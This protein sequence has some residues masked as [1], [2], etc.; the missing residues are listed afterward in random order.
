[1]GKRLDTPQGRLI[2]SYL[3][4]INLILSHIINDIDSLDIE[5][6]KKFYTDIIVSSLSEYEI[7]IIM[8]FMISHQTNRLTYNIRKLNFFDN[9]VIQDSNYLSIYIEHSI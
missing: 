6:G 5:E 8:G 7:V 9:V 4:I 2:L 1:M 3:N